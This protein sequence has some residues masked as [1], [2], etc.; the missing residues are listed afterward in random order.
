MAELEYG[1]GS[2]R[3]ERKP[4]VNSLSCGQKECITALCDTFL[5]SISVANDANVDESI[6][7]FLGTSAS[8]AGTPQRVEELIEE[9]M[10]HPKLWLLRLAFWMLSTWLGTFILCGRRSLSSNF[11][12]F[13]KFSKVS[14][15]KREEIVLSWSVSYFSIMRMLFLG[16][17]FVT[18]LAFFTQVNDKN[19]NVSWK[20]IGYCGPDPDFKPKTQKTKPPKDQSS[21]HQGKQ[22]HDVDEEEPF[23]PLHQGIIN[24]NNPRQ[25]VLESLHKLGFQVSLP[26]HKTNT[27]NSRTP[28]MII[29]CDA[30][31]VGSGSG[32][33]VVAGLLAKQGYKVLVLEKGKYYARRNLSLLE[34]HAMDQMYMGNGLLATEDMG[35]VILAGCT[36]GGGS[37]VNWSASIRT[38]EH[39]LKEWSEEHE[40]ELFESELYREAMDVVCEKM[41]VQYV[42]EDEGF[43][44]EV[45][46]RGCEKLGYPVK[47]IPRNS[48]A[49][50]SCGWC[51]FGCKDGRKKGTSETWLVD[52]VKSGNGVILPECHAVK[53]LHKR[54][55]GRAR[56][57][58]TGV[59]FEFHP[60]DS[61]KQLYI[62]QS[63]VTVIAC[64]ALNT[65]PLLK[66]SGLKNPSIGKNLHLHPVVMAWGYFPADPLSQSGP[67][68]DKK[69]YQG[70]IMTAM[71]TIVSN[72]STTGYGAILQT[73]SLHPGMYS[74]LTPWVSGTNIK[75]QMCKFSRT[76]HIISIARDK[77]TGEVISPNRIRY[78]IDEFDEGN[79]HRGVAAA[80]SILAAA[81]AEEIGT[82]HGNGRRGRVRE[83][84]EREVEEFVRE[85]SGRVV[86]PLCSAHQMGSCRM[87]AEEGRSAVDQRGEAWEVEGLFVADASVFPTALGVNPMVTVQAIAYCTA[88]AV[89]EVLRRKKNDKK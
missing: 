1:I 21:E 58:A 56:S 79:L 67:K 51:C 50:H 19:E 88:Q 39:V 41:G 37:T 44:N 83:M 33:G 48:P 57:T 22:D 7:M 66:S 43:S 81:G 53:V 85:E 47:N 46:R 72:F 59:A 2:P 73:P 18:L 49:D 20:A 61:F 13:Q 80:L 36:V 29:K 82:H 54:K 55:K 16:T 60:A 65:P 24:L 5:P 32:G 30:V 23:G 8:M 31:V 34:G 64:G 9:R 84:S 86:T 40:L 38:P 11:P 76:S 45:L 6:A 3:G 27:T 35:V 87:G 26:N 4:P 25:I 89:V 75:H 69:S 12:Y 14:Q 77:G 52:M 78:Q 63:K 62:V 68:P 15:K 42:V 17:K 74:V 10:Q 28:S 71:S 70:G